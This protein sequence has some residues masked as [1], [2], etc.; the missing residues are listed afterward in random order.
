MKSITPI[1]LTRER[2][3]QQKK[4][5]SLAEAKVFRE[6][7]GQLCWLGMGAYPMGY[8]YGSYLQQRIGDLRVRHFCLAN[9]VIAE[10]KEFDATI[11]YGLVEDKDRSFRGG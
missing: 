3:R 8:F 7:A 9:G 6:K 4:S 1:K 11:V 10:A 5:A 2:R